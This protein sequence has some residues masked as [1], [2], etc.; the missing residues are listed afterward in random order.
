VETLAKLVEMDVLIVPVPQVAQH[1]S[2]QET[3]LIM[4]MELVLV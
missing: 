3:Q 2:I 1:V 4:V